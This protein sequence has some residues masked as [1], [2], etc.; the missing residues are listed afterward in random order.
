MRPGVSAETLVSLCEKEAR[1]N[2][3]KPVFQLDES[4]PA[5]Q[6][7]ES[8]PLRGGLLPASFVVSMNPV[9]RRAAAQARSEADLCLSSTLPWLRQDAPRPPK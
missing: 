6:R 9:E 7:A 5:R 2:Q 8:K 4:L 3:S 1:L